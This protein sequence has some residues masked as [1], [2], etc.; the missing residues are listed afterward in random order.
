MADP[1]GNDR[2]I[3]LFGFE[4]RRTPTEDPN[5]K[6]SIVPAKDDDGAGYVTASG[7][8]YGQYINLDGDDSKDNAQLIM[9][10]RGTAMHPECDAAL[11]DI[12]G[13]AI[14][15]ANEEN[16]Q[17]ININMDNLKV[18]DGIKKQIKEEF[19]NI[20]SM[21]NFNEDGHDIFKRWYTDGRI[22]H[23]LV[24]DESKLRAGIQE[25]RHIDSSKMRKIK[26]VKRKKDPQT[27]ANLIERVDE[28]YIY[29]EKPGHHSSG[30]KLSTDAV[31]YVTS[32]LLDETRKKVLSYLHKALKPLNQLRMMEDSLV[33]YRLSRAP[34][35]R[36]FYIDVGNLPRGKAEQYM[37]DI[38]S[39]YRNKI[40]YD[41]KTGEIRDDRKH[42]SMIEDFW[43]PRRE[44]GRGTEIATLPGGQNLGEIDDIIYFQKKLYKA[45]NVPINRLEQEA[46]F[47]LGRSSEIT[48]DELKFQKFIERIRVRFA[49]LF[50]GILKTQLMLKGI[51]TEEDWGNLKND[52]TI[53]YSKDNHFTELKEAELLRERLQTLDQAS[54]YVGTYFSKEWI[55]KTI[56]KLDDE[57]IDNMADQ[58]SEEEQPREEE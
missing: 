46:Q 39:R 13:E 2:G 42:M 44:G 27:G 1:T 49:H 12:C 47:S 54:Q 38:M 16:K 48:R 21:L 20:I 25:I 22:Y 57:E 4:L 34:E 29:Q 6:P 53:D 24:V 14:V 15:S 28:F 50:L 36:M 56:L 18:S 32:G 7:S 52:L 5:K 55:M 8:H 43:I 58:A 17:S 10:Y 11:E 33:I 41:A 37:K 26:Q 19:D 40:V 30:V 45:L 23:H 35:R 51:I 3:R 31:S 9:K